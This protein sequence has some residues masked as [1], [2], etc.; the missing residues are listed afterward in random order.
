MERRGQRRRHTHL[1]FCF[2]SFDRRRGNGETRPIV[3]LDRRRR[4]R[5]THLAANLRVLAVGA[6]T[7]AERR[8]A[9]GRS[10][11]SLAHRERSAGV[12]GMAASATC[13]SRR[14]ETEIFLNVF[15]SSGIVSQATQGSLRCRVHYVVRVNLKLSKLENSRVS[16]IL[17]LSIRHSLVLELVS[18][19]GIAR[20][21]G[22]FRNPRSLRY[23]RMRLTTGRLSASSFASNVGKN[24]PA[25][26]S[27]ILP[28]CAPYADHS[29]NPACFVND[30]SAVAC[31]QNTTSFTLP[32]RE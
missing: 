16:F 3:S 5:E 30:S 20:P 29:A 25:M 18:V 23:V 24:S 32:I 28:N 10:V 17:V 19:F 4:R 22:G 31:T 13:L 6:K 14:P 1:H 21:S 9:G 11:T 26:T 2:E 7:L 27:R 8:G 15:F 12:R